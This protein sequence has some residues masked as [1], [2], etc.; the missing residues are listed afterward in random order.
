M[1]TKTIE[2][3][4]QLL[5]EHVKAAAAAGY[6]IESQT[7]EMAIVVSGKPVNH[8]LHFLIGVFTLGLWWIMWIILAVGGGEKRWMISLDEH[9]N[10]TKQKV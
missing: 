1:Q 5:A 9:G 2:E 4:Q 7:H 3:R 6:R 8:L 10:V